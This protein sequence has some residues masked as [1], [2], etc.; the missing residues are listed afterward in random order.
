MFKSI[1]K[2]YTM[3]SPDFLAA[4]ML[5]EAQLELLKAEAFKE[6]YVATVDMLRTRVAR[7]NRNVNS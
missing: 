6:H 5:H 2:M 7:L 4:Q 3:P 1:K